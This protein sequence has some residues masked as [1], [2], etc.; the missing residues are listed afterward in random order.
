LSDAVL[1][2]DLAQID[3]AWGGAAD[4]TYRMVLGIFAPEAEGLRAGLADALANQ[5]TASIVRLAHTLRGAAANV[6]ASRLAACAGALERAAAQGDLAA[7]PALLLALDAAVGA[8][9]AEI[10]G[11]GPA[12]SG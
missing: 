11:G 2:F 10:A 6:A 12:E 3:E 5:D 9:C 8:T 7:L 1:L 4:E